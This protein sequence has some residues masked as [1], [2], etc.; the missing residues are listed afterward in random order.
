MIIIKK[1]K[2]VAEKKFPYK[3]VGDIPIGKTF[4]AT[5]L[6]SGYFLKAYDSL[7]CLDNPQTTWAED[8]GFSWMKTFYF[9]DLELREVAKKESI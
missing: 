4:Y 8:A 6:H 2:S 1:E 9:C 5:G 3:T 7:I